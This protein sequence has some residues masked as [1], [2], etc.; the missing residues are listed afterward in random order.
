[1]KKYLV[2]DQNYLRDKDL[3]RL[4][5]DDTDMNFVV[6]DVALMEMCKSTSWK[7]IALSSLRILSACPR[8]AHLS[9]GIG[10]AIQY[11]L[12]YKCSIQ[13]RL[14]DKELTIFFRNLLDEVS[15]KKDGE[16]FEIMSK[17]MS[18]IQK[19]LFQCRELNGYDNKRRLKKL[20]D[21][22]GALIGT[23][24]QKLFRKKLISRQ[25][26]IEAIGESAPHFIK[27][28]LLQMKFPQNR[29][30]SFLKSNPLILRIAYSRLWMSFYWEENGG[31]D[32]AKEERITNDYADQDYI[33]TATFFDGF[34]SK[35]KNAEEAYINIS[36]V[37]SQKKY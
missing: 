10:E 19:D 4:I 36:N 15:Q 9:I 17:G 28:Y 37:I 14:F 23:A 13:G 27:A 22:L 11:E 29:I 35:D 20:N 5:T 16:T 33:L 32:A 21:S 34:L 1:M 8:R 2:V 31:F 24:N 6:P 30:T 7:S 18:D 25:D 3:Q 26:K 12:T